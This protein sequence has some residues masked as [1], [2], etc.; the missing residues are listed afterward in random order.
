[1]YFHRLVTLGSAQRAVT[2][3]EGQSLADEYG[4]PFCEVSATNAEADVEGV[5]R[6]FITLAGLV[7][8]RLIAEGPIVSVRIILVPLCL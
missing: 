7:K 3:E 2:Y 5:E 4:I 1:M 8:D 6:A